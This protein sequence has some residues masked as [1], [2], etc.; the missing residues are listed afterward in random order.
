MV[1][2]KYPPISEPHRKQIV[3]D[4][5]AEQQRRRRAR[6]KARDEKDTTPPLEHYT[7]F[8]EVG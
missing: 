7:D 2:D 8:H 4:Y 3:R 1:E 5:R 6:A